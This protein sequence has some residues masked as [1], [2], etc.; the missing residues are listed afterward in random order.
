MIESHSVSRVAGKR[1]LRF[2]AIARAGAVFVPIGRTVKAPK[3]T[4]ILADC[5]P[6]AVFTDAR[7][8]PV[9]DEAMLRAPGV[10]VIVGTVG[11][12][13]VTAPEGVDAV[14]FAGLLQLGTG[15]DVRLEAI[16]LDLC[17][18]IYT[19]GSSGRAK[20]VM[21]S[22][23]N[24]LSAT[25]SINSYLRTRQTTSSL[26]CCRCRSTT[27]CINCFWRFSSGAC[28]VLERAFTIRRRSS[29]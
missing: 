22:H 17:A 8:R 27:A 29:N 12:G 24:M 13:S 20:G 6:V 25:A 21:L 19:S 2:S 9:V 1:W 7:M 23:A 3:L 26:M 5:A 28:L 10:R 4:Q 16:D 11:D 18:L 14:S 15:R